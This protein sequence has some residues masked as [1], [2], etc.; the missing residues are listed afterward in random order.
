[1]PWTNIFW[2]R[3]WRGRRGGYLYHHKHRGSVCNHQL[4]LGDEAGAVPQQLPVHDILPSGVRADHWDACTHPRRERGLGDRHQ[5]RAHGGGHRGRDQRRRHRR[6]E[7]LPLRDQPAGTDKRNDD[8]HHAQAAAFGPQGIAPGPRLRKGRGPRLPSRR[9][10]GTARREHGRVHYDL[11]ET[12]QG[13]G[14]GRNGRH[15]RRS[16][17]GKGDYEKKRTVAEAGDSFGGRDRP[18]VG[19]NES[20]GHGGHDARPDLGCCH[21]DRGH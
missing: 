14:C 8:R 2:L 7:A 19:G 16:E 1:M 12:S 13:D 18:H 20:A 4:D 6:P 11:H 3:E 15:S 9:S 10:E 21:G 5:G 17:F